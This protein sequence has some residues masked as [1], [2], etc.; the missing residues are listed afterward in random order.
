VQPELAAAVE[1]DRRLY[2]RAAEQ[3]TELPGG[4]AYR[5]CG[6]PQLYMLNGVRLRAPLPADV[7]A[8]EIQ[9]IA[10]AAM[11]GL[12][13]RHVVIADASAGERLSAAL[14]RSGWER[15]RTEFMVWRDDPG[16]TVSDPRARALSEAELRTCQLADLR[17]A[18]YASSA[19][20]A[21]MIVDG[22][23][24]VRAAT[25]CRAFGAGEDGGIQS[26]ATLFLDP[27][28]DGH[29]VA[30][31]ESVG[32]LRS[33]RERGLAK[34]AV[35]AA[36]RAAVEWSAELVVVPVDADDWPQLLYAGLGFVP[37]G[38]QIAFTRPPGSG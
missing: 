38:R 27:D 22:L 34:A 14:E 1:L 8:V 7:G 24:A 29:R 23:A 32:T 21:E 18:E 2:I 19:P 31:V 5:H 28:V 17:Q 9:A 33:Y 37:A 26:S 25:E 16:P 13:H 6:L 20:L 12:G 4:W 10:D 36:V 3:V 35:S 15:Q 30:M 11:A